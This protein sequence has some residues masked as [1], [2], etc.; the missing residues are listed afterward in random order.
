MSIA[1]EEQESPRKEDF[2]RRANGVSVEE[3]QSYERCEDRPTL[4]D[5]RASP[6]FELLHR[7]HGA[8]DRIINCVKFVL[9]SSYVGPCVVCR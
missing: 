1:S 5:L 7:A 6:V 2:Q 9:D 8:E 4:K 3:Y